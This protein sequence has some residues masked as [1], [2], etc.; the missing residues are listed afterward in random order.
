MYSPCVVINYMLFSS[1]GSKLNDCE[2]QW[3]QIKN[4]V[5]KLSLTKLIAITLCQILN[6]LGHTIHN[7][8]FNDIVNSYHI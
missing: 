5:I 1:A 8:I 2:T 6:I 4:S 7:N 3:N